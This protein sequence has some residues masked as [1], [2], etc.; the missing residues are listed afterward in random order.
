MGRGEWVMGGSW[1]EMDTQG[2]VDIKRAVE[3]GSWT[4]GAFW[5]M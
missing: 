5:R 3:S 4:V 1:V 2:R